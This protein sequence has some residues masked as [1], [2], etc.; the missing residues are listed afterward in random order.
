MSLHRMMKS[1]EYGDDKPEDY[2]EFGY[3][4]TLQKRMYIIGECLIRSKGFFYDEY[5][6]AREH[7]IQRAKNSGECF[8]AAESDRK[9]NKNIVVGETYMRNKKNMTL[10]FWS[11]RNASWRQCRTLLHFVYVEWMKL[12][13]EDVRALYAIEYLGHQREMNLQMCLNYESALKAEKES[14]ELE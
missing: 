14:E 4:T 12:L 9:E 8:V 5:Q 11:H 10:R 2:K 3:N 7:L 13:G 1:E 6:K